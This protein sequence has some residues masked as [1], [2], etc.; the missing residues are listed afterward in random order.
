M[1]PWGDNSMSSR[2][3]RQRTTIA[4]VT[5][6]SLVSCTASALTWNA[7]EP[8]RCRSTRQQQ[9]HPLQQPQQQYASHSFSKSSSSLPGRSTRFHQQQ[10]QQQ[11]QYSSNIF[12]T[13][14]NSAPGPSIPIPPPYVSVAVSIDQPLITDTLWPVGSK[15]KNLTPIVVLKSLLSLLT[16]NV[17]RVALIAF[18]AALIVSVAV[19]SSDTLLSKIQTNWKLM[20]GQVQRLLE[21]IRKPETGTPMPFEVDD[22]S[23]GI[24]KLG[25]GVCTLRSKRR[26]GKSSFVQYDFDLPEPDYVLPLDLGQQVSL[27]CLDNDNSV[28]KGDFFIYSP[29][30]MPRPGQFSILAPNSKSP[31]AN[32]FA[33]GQ[34][35][36][37]FVRVLKQ[38]MKVGDEIAI[39]PGHR[40]LA[41]RGQY[42][43]VTDM[44]YIAIGAGVVPVLDQV[45]AVLPNGS[46]SVKGV[47]VV[48][49]NDQ[50]KDFDVTAELLEKEYFK[51]ST[52]LAVSCVVDD[53][54]LH[55]IEDN[56]EINAVVPDF[57]QGTMAVLAGPEAMTKKA[58]AYLEERGYPEDTICVL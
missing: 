41:Y 45:R 58:A 37:N 17:V 33:V 9:R 19:R 31:S 30:P 24:D 5:T 27:C 15:A 29:E 10:Q 28:A 40:R 12:H 23:S 42:L 32:E 2:R 55:A 4:I 20:N 57:Q 6:L 48:W 26:L 18:C 56:V 11:Q 46:S 35:A 36:A 43:P 52:K 13:S 1:A 21:R 25:W 50:A 53:L 3:R 54:Q 22:K 47:T 38:D 14:L 44:V 34:D 49:I 51:Y 16:L 8:L 7:R 39:R